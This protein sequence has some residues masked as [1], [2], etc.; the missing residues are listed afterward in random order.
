MSRTRL[1]VLI[2]VAVMVGALLLAERLDT[3]RAALHET[4]DVNYATYVKKKSFIER[5]LKAG[6]ETRAALKEL[7]ESESHLIPQADA[8]LAFAELQA[9]VQDIAQSAGMR[10]YAIRQLQSVSSRGYVSLP[11]FV[12]MRGDIAR[13]STFLRELDAGDDFI[14]IDN[15]NVTASQEGALRVRLQLSGLMKP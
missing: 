4:L 5:T 6:A 2:A 7:Q 9:R 12:E 13:F 1:L 11:L 15:M 8:S 3:E 14:G 10:I